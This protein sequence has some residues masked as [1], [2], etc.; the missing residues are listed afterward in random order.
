MLFEKVLDSFLAACFKRLPC[1]CPV[2]KAYYS[3]AENTYLPSE[4]EL[5]LGISATSLKPRGIEKGAKLSI[6]EW[7]SKILDTVVLWRACSKCVMLSG[8]ELLIN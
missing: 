8:L 6:R 2:E 7:S 4:I 3:L 1:C 5:L